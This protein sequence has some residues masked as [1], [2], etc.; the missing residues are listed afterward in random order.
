MYEN[1]FLPVLMCV[2]R[3]EGGDGTRVELKDAKVA[4][5]ACSTRP[6]E[7]KPVATKSYNRSVFLPVLFFFSKL[8]IPFR[9]HSQALDVCFARST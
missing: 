8:G 2:V 7:T 6:I 5:A 4:A 9:R 3:R 1:N